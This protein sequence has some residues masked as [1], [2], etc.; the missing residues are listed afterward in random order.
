MNPKLVPA[1]AAATVT[2]TSQIRHLCRFKNEV[3]DGTVTVVW[4][5]DGATIEL[6]SLA[7]YFASFAEVLTSHEEL[8]ARIGEDL[9]ALGDD[10]IVRSVTVRFTTAG[11]DVEA[12]H[13]VSDHTLG[14]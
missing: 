1:D 12:T 6:H 10:I 3:D 13:V 9:D 2:A 8:V 11:I 4:T 5:C 14:A 7:E